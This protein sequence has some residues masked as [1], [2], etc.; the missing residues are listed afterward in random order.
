MIALILYTIVWIL[1]SIVEGVREA[2]YFD[3]F[4][5]PT[6]FNIH[7]IFMLQRILV[8]MYAVD[9]F[10]WTIGIVYA[11]FFPFFH[12]GAYYFTRH[13][14]NKGVYAKGFWD[15]PSKSSTALM[16][17]PTWM[18]ILLLGCGVIILTAIM[19]VW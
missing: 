18:R 9:V 6:K 1:Y 4:P 15:Q 10:H 12:D 14:L 16:D 7:I 5:R 17:F 8:L 13:M 19:I 11:C 3:N 2:Y